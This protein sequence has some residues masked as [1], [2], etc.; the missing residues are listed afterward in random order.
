MTEATVRVERRGLEIIVEVTDENGNLFTRTL[1]DPDP[2][3]TRMYPQIT[4]FIE[5]PLKFNGEYQSDV[6]VG[7][8][9][10]D[11]VTVEPAN[12]LKFLRLPSGP[13]T[14]WQSVFVTVD[15]VKR[16]ITTDTWPLDT[17]P[18]N[19]SRRP[20]TPPSPA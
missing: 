16:E 12:R 9:I 6:L 4:T 18:D 15:G 13:L 5:G 2:D 20:T 1:Q 17:F 3:G 14:S 8:S 10:G 11:E 19:P 7:F